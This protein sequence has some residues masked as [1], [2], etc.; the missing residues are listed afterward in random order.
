MQSKACQIG[1]GKTFVM[2]ETLW[3]IKE[4]RAFILFSQRFILSQNERELTQAEF[5]R[6]Y[7]VWLPPLVY[8]QAHYPLRSAVQVGGS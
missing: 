6:I 5:T 4:Q 3:R 2:A 1:Y 7:L 8:F